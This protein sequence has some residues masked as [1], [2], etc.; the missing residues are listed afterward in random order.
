MTLAHGIDL[1]RKT[2]MRDI[3]A[4][5]STLWVIGFYMLNVNVFFFLCS[6]E[7]G[8]VQ[9]KVRIKKNKFQFEKPSS[10]SRVMQ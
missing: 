5:L 4:P 7:N 3:D 10:K 2:H 8:R 1:G 9:V 6:M